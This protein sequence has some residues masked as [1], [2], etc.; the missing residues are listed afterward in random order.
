MAAGAGIGASVLAIGALCYSVF[1]SYPPAV[2]AAL[3]ANNPSGASGA[4]A[5]GAVD[6]CPGTNGA[7]SRT[8]PR[9]EPSGARSTSVWSLRVVAVPARA[10]FVRL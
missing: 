3:A 6:Y 4:Y 10:M 7:S 5:V 2:R 1:V 9:T 8:G